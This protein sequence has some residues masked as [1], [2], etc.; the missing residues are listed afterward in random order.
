MAPVPLLEGT[1]GKPPAAPI[2]HTDDVS[3]MILVL[4]SLGIGIS[5]VVTILRCATRVWV[6]KAFGVDDG[7]M[8]AAML[9]YSVYILLMMVN[10]SFGLGHT[11]IGLLPQQNQV[12]IMRDIWMGYIFYFCTM[13]LAKSSIGWFLLRVTINRTHHQIVYTAIGATVSSC[14]LAAFVLA[15]QCAPV[16]Y[17]WDRSNPGSGVCTEPGTLIKASFYPYGAVTIATDFTLALLPAW[18]VSHLQ[19]NLKTKLALIGLMALGCLSSSAVIARWVLFARESDPNSSY[20]ATAEIA[21]WTMTEQFL[22]ITVGSLATLRPLLGL[23]RYKLGWGGSPRHETVCLNLNMAQNIG[24]YDAARINIKL[25]EDDLR[26]R[27]ML[28][29]YG[30]AGEHRPYGE[31]LNQEQPAPP[32]A[33]DEVDPDILPSKMLKKIDP[34]AMA[35]LASV[36]FYGDLTS[37]LAF[38]T[39]LDRYLVREKQWLDLMEQVT[40]HYLSRIRT[41][42]DDNERMQN[43]FLAWCYPSFRWAL[44]SFPAPDRDAYAAAV[45]QAARSIFNTK[46]R[47]RHPSLR[48]IADA[49]L[50]HG[51]QLSQ[52][53]EATMLP[54]WKGLVE[55]LDVQYCMLKIDAKAREESQRAFEEK[56]LAACERELKAFGRRMKL[57]ILCRAREEDLVSEIRGWA[58]GFC[59]AVFLYRA[60]MMATVL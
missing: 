3:P 57:E 38:D 37:Q 35:E 16:N 21:A 33:A 51:K 53:F 46:F 47:F 56:Q 42:H 9:T 43:E 18:I 7:L 31:M 49:Y 28:S 30:R 6:V 45:T 44:P 2:G 59:F 15:F 11:P 20:H 13:A 12:I 8:S 36:L 52:A 17:F 23:V 10:L 27:L 55:R 48:A 41:I 54:E 24:D 25:S 1:A 50:D 29:Y 26:K 5:V 40:T 34:K 22:I 14:L 60:C 4:A 19:M 32:P 58:F 39:D